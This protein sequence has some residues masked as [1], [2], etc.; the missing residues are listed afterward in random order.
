MWGH[1]G[2]KTETVTLG[3]NYFF[4]D[5]AVILQKEIKRSPSPNQILINDINLQRCLRLK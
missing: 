1:S 4:A 3:D 2:H 5:N